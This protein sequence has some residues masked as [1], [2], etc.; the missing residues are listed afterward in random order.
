MNVQ[1]E[2]EILC[3]NICRLRKKYQLSKREMAKILGIGIY[4]LTKIESGVIPPKLGCEMLFR[5]YDNF[6]IKPRDIFAPLKI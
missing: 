2:S 3:S 1:K 4:S 5:I 6:E